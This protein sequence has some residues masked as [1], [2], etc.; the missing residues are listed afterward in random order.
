MRK[1]D[2]PPPILRTGEDQTTA[3]QATRSVKGTMRMATTTTASAVAVRCV[4]VR[5]S[6]S[7]SAATKWNHPGRDVQPA[8]VLPRSR[9]GVPA[10]GIMAMA[11][12]AGCRSTPARPSR[13]QLPVACIYKAVY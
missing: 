13:P 12:P 8:G 4:H 2:D 6:P 11:H 9:I 3:N 10:S 7:S 1:G 5:R